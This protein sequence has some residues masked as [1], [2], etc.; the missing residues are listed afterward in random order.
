MGLW[1]NLKTFVNVGFLAGTD[2]TVN[3]VFGDYDNAASAQADVNTLAAIIDSGIT[4]RHF[5]KRRPQ[6]QL[7][8]EDL[9]GVEREEPE[10]KK[11]EDP[12]EAFIKWFNSLGD[13]D[14]KFIKD[15]I[16]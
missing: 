2:A 5:S 1:T 3:K 16:K 13:D 4:V 11:S 14:K 10:E 7:Y 6:Q 15:A 9:L 8:L 12:K